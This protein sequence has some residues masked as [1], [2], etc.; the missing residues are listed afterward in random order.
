MINSIFII[1][2]TNLLRIVEM[3][4]VIYSISHIWE[5]AEMDSNLGLSEF[6]SDILSVYTT[7]HFYAIK[8]FVECVRQEVI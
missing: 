6:T 2:I 1:L 4:A 8:S 5:V 7:W 3:N